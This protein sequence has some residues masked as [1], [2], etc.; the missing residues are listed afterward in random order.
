MAKP[1]PTLLPVLHDVPKCREWAGSVGSKAGYHPPIAPKWTRRLDSV[2]CT[3]S[4]APC[5]SCW[6]WSA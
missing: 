1:V 3:R 4:P 5:C 6:W 2:F